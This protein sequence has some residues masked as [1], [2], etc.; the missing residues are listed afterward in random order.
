MTLKK[1]ARQRRNRGTSDNSLANPREFDRNSVKRRQVAEEAARIIAGESIR[2]Y[3]LAKKKASARLGHKG[4]EA[5]PT[6]QE[7]EAALNERLGLFAADRSSKRMREAFE[8][9]TEA[10]QFLAHFD[11]RLS[12]SLVRGRI[13]DNM[14]VELHLFAGTPEEVTMSLIEEDIPFELFDRRVRYGGNRYEQVTGVRLQADDVTVEALIFDLQAQ[15]EPPLSPIDGQTMERLDYKS[16]C[17]K[18]QLLSV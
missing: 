16:A 14:P 7:I 5:L 10:M 2:D 13:T 9:A 6:N 4:I 18:R 3:Q 11:P 15:R 12:G 8:V 1:N 17:A